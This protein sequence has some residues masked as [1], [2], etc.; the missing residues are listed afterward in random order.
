MVSMTPASFSDALRQMTAVDLRSI[1]AALHDDSTGDEV[2]G[3]RA[4]IAI[5]RALRHAHR[6]RE[7]AHAAWAAAQAVQH[8]AEADGLALP[9]PEVTRVARAAAEI[10]RGLVAGSEV[11]AEVDRLLAQWTPLA[12]LR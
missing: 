4:T 8:A 3:W 11:Q 6:A 10:A 9:D 2:D 1:A 12:A 7:A 5:D